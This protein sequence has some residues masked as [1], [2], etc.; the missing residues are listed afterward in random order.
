MTRR[1][2]DPLLW[3][4]FSNEKTSETSKFHE[5]LK[6]HVSLTV[7]APNTN[8]DV[9]EQIAKLV[10]IHI[11][12]LSDDLNQPVFS[13]GQSFFGFAGDEFDKI[14]DNYDSLQWWLSDIGLNIAT[15]VRPTLLGAE[16]ASGSKAAEIPSDQ[17]FT[18][19]YAVSQRSCGIPGLTLQQSFPAERYSLIGGPGDPKQILELS[20]EIGWLA[21]RIQVLEGPPGLAPSEA[22]DRLLDRVIGRKSGEIEIEFALSELKK[23]CRASSV[24]RLETGE[25]AKAESFEEIAVRFEGLHAKYFRQTASTVTFENYRKA[26]DPRF[27]QQHKAEFKELLAEGVELHAL[28]SSDS[29]L[30]FGPWRVFCKPGDP[31]SQDHIKSRFRATARKAAIAAG[32]P[33][34]ANLLD[35]WISKLARGKRLHY[36]QGLIKLSTDFCAELE[37][38]AAELRPLVDE[39]NTVLGLRRDRYPCDH[40]V[41][42]SL[43]TEPHRPLA[44]P[45]EEFAFWDGRVWESFVRSIEEIASGRRDGRRWIDADGV[46]HVEP[47]DQAR[48]RVRKRVERR[49]ELLTAWTLG[50]SYDVAVLQANY[51][52]DRRLRGEGAIRA[53]ELESTELV[54]KIRQSWRAASKQWGLSWKKQ[55]KKEIDFSKPFRDVCADL[56]ELIFSAFLVGDQS[57]ESATTVPMASDL[58]RERPVDA[59]SPTNAIAA[60]IERG[61]ARPDSKIGLSGQLKAAQTSNLKFRKMHEAVI[62]YE[63][64]K[65]ELQT[66]KV[67]SKKYQTPEL[68]KV[69][70]ADFDIWATLDKNDELDIAAG[71]FAPGRFSWSLVK[72]LNNLEGKDDRTLK[73]YRRALKA[74]GILPL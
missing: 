15:I 58:D 41:P 13:R 42:Y 33:S 22:L 69:H 31:H 18:P 36:I 55:E 74:A 39:L 14:A 59:P 4:R 27:S 73:N 57:A 62:R 63:W 71:A 70:Y 29:S 21:R 38:N 49:T 47:N 30:D 24:H 65:T 17:V 26:T 53:F 51:I 3:R 46:M 1:Q 8:R 43:Y 19:G 32:A 56:R 60:G 9:V 52:I 44:D 2:C 16:V 6:T 11:E 10:G 72:R 12:L 28:N 50:L 34:R 66:L 7:P 61:G 25:P 35:W 23:H 45:K 68:L 67:A 40:P 37:S 20:G 64:Y 54:E 5:S 48:L